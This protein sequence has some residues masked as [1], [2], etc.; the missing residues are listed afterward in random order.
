MMIKK[1]NLNFIMSLLWSILIGCVFFNFSVG[2]F[3]VVCT[4]IIYM[5]A[6]NFFSEHKKIIS[7]IFNIWMT[8]IGIILIIFFLMTAQYGIPYDMSGTDDYYT[9]AVWSDGLIED[10]ILTLSQINSSGKWSNYN[11]KL[12]LIII[13]W[14]KKLTGYIGGYHTLDFRIFSMMLWL[15][16]AM[17]MGYYARK[18]LYAT[19]KEV[20]MI[21]SV[22]GLLPNAVFISSLVYRDTIVTFLVVV[23]FYLCTAFKKH[24]IY[25]KIIILFSIFMILYLTYYTR[26]QAVVFVLANILIA[27]MYPFH[28]KCFFHLGLYFRKI[29]TVLAVIVGMVA[30]RQILS[31]QLV[32][33]IELYTRLHSGSSGVEGFIYGLPI[34]PFGWAIRMLYYLLLPLY[35]RDIVPLNILTDPLSLLRCYVTWGSLFMWTLYPYVIRYLRKMNNMC[36]LLILEWFVAAVI[37]GGFRHVMVMYPLLITIA[38]H[39]RYSAKGVVEPAP[40]NI[41]ALE[42]CLCNENK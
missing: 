12:Q 25:E 10:G 35:I 24:R 15:I 19:E 8:E 13:V 31:H 29:F 23:S 26:A 11:N 22:M 2:L 40:K 16:T 20:K 5:V 36:V 17:I 21:I 9:D 42:G 34:L 6:V 7:S 39:A 3:G 33:Y 4:I 37:T 32:Y 28:K 41:K 14:M 38:V 1:T 27:Y 30:V 18:Y